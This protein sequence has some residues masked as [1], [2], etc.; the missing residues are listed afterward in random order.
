MFQ[1]KPAIDNRLRA[2]AQSA[3]SITAKIA[4]IILYRI[5]LREMKELLSKFVE[6][7]VMIDVLYLE[8]KS[9]ASSAAYMFEALP[10]AR[11]TLYL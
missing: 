5:I 6:E 4:T 1:T 2:T 9:G 7:L 3:T 11:D 10:R 8:P